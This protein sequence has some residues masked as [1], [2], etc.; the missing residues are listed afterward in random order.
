M[1]SIT[2]PRLAML[3]VATTTLGLAACNN[4]ADDATEKAA[5]AV[6]ARSD[7]AADILN[8]RADLETGAAKDA[9]EKKADAVKAEGEKKADALEDKADAI[10]RQ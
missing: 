3:A 2:L 1:K 4:P 9:L 6:E 7:A 10:V 5:D 8:E